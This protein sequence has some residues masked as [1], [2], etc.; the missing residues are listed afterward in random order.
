MVPRARAGIR[1]RRRPRPAS[2][3]SSGE[4][5]RYSRSRDFPRVSVPAVLDGAVAVSA[6]RWRL[7]AACNGWRPADT[8]LFPVWRLSTKDR[9]GAGGGGGGLPCRPKFEERLGAR[10]S[11]F[12]CRRCRRHSC[13]HIDGTMKR[14]SGKTRAGA[15]LTTT[16]PGGYALVSPVPQKLLSKRPPMRRSNLRSISRGLRDHLRAELR[17]KRFVKEL[18]LKIVPVLVLRVSQQGRA[19][20][21]GRSGG[22]P[23]LASR[24][25]ST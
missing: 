15:S 22:L 5:Y 6:R 14:L 24:Y 11:V 16:Y 18:S 3:A 13:R 12:S 25:S 21:V 1:L 19:A 2:G 4:Y 20:D 8:T 17:T 7:A 10:P 9:L 23:S